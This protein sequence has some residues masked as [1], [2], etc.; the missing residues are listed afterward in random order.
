VTLIR[1]LLTLIRSLLT[2]IRSLLTLIIGPVGVPH[3]KPRRGPR[4]LGGVRQVTVIRSLLTL[5]RSL[6]KR[7]AATWR[8]ASSHGICIL[9]T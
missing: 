2:L 6:L 8:R 5:I 9:L 4:Q 1:S 3:G 7:H